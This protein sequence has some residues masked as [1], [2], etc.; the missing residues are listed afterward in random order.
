M[1]ARA[2]ALL[3][4]LRAPLRPYKGRPARAAIVLAGL[5]VVWAVICSG[6][7]CDDY[8][9]S[10]RAAWNLAHGY[11]LVYNPGER[12]QAFTNPLWTLLLAGNCLITDDH[13]P[14]TVALSLAALLGIL[15]LLARLAAPHPGAL[16]I[17]LLLL[18][19][20]KSFVD[21]STSGLEN[22][23]SHLLY[24]AF[25]VRWSGG[26]EKRPCQRAGQ[27]GLLAALLI[28]NRLDLALLVLPHLVAL[29][30]RMPRA[31]WRP[32]ALGLLPLL[33]WEAF[34]VVYYGSPFP[35][36]AWAK[37]SGTGLD[38]TFILHRGWSY[39]VN[40]ILWDRVTL[41]ALAAALGLAVASPLLRRRHLPTALGLLLYLLYLVRIGGDYMAG[42]YLS[43][44]LVG[45]AALL[46]LAPAWRRRGLALAGAAVI[47]G[48]SLSSDRS[49]LRVLPGEEGRE[50]QVLAY[51]VEDVR[52]ANF[53]K[54][55]LL[56]RVLLGTLFINQEEVQRFQTD[57]GVH[58]FG[59]RPFITGPQVHMINSF[60]LTDPLLARMPPQSRG[61]I[62]AGHVLKSIPPG[63]R[64]SLITGENHIEDPDVARLWDD[65]VLATRA[66]LFSTARWA[67]IWRLHTGHHSKLLHKEIP[68]EIF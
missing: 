57:M 27:L 28:W 51:E 8:Y 53:G 31:V 38:L 46:V 65:L 44:P 34:S 60:G 52:Q 20:S 25:L 19:G 50:W 9:L 14:A 18:A 30:W 67:A 64:R 43:L 55:G 6:W 68:T 39:I 54:D 37:L 35:N 62:R 13:Y 32:L 17:G 58:P 66:P 47:L 61:Q 24:L 29:L 23:L 12:V 15:L 10:L 59:R 33:I 5:L 1:K 4:S 2:V 40:S 26:L 48:A 11:G 42:R 45:A 3:A 16:M 22:P 36:T 7:I 56:A 21:Y 41:P 49:P 63:Y